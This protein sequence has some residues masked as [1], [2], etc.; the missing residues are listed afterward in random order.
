M[1]TLW[2]AMSGGKDWEEVSG[3]L[4]KNV[5]PHMGLL[6]SLYIA[7]CFLSLLNIITGVY[8]D[9]AM[10]IGRQDKDNY[11]ISYLRHMFSKLDVDHSGEISWLELEHNWEHGEF[12]ELLN[13]IGLDV[14]EAQNVFK[15]LD[16]NGTGSINAEEFLAGCIRLRSDA[17]ALD[18][19]V[20]MRETRRMFNK[21][22]AKLHEIHL[23]LTD[24]G[25][26]EV[27]Q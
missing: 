1:L 8:V 9:S 11:L 15:L 23:D 26:Y 16:L 17:K 20:L 21:T 10:K 22:F 18:M 3:P 13:S 6:Y 24:H 4:L 5:G 25:T 27:V 2:Q 14:S 19:M 7:F 12:E